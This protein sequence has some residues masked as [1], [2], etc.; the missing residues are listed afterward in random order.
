MLK[1]LE[2]WATMPTYKGSMLLA[3]AI[4]FIAVAVFSA[5]LI[6][7]HPSLLL[8][9]VLLLVLGVYATFASWVLSTIASLSSNLLTWRLMS[10]ACL[11]LPST[12]AGSMVSAY[13]NNKPETGDELKIIIFSLG[14]LVGSYLIQLVLAKFCKEGS[15][16]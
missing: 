9:W 14:L 6:A 11:L 5:L 8:T 10:W 15:G 12:L 7:I 1:K 13:L 2:K 3:M 16:V 4:I